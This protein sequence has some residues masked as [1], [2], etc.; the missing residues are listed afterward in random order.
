MLVV[1]GV[2]AVV[3]VQFST[4]IAFSFAGIEVRVQRLR[5]GRRP[6]CDFHKRFLNYKLRIESRVSTLRS[7]MLIL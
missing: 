1:F 7:S 2:H 3:G 4:T 5:Y 6:K